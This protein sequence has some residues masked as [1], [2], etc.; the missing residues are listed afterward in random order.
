MMSTEKDGLEFVE[1][2]RRKKA[3]EV[4]ATQEKAKSDLKKENKLKKKLAMEEIE[5]A[6]QF[7]PEE[8]RVPEWF[9]D[10]PPNEFFDPGIFLA[11]PDADVIHLQ[12]KTE[13]K[14]DEESGELITLLSLRKFPRPIICSFVS[15]YGEDVG[16]RKD[17]M[18]GNE[19]ELRAKA[20][21]YKPEDIVNPEALTK[22]VEF[23]IFNNSL[24]TADREL[25]EWEDAQ[26]EPAQIPVAS[27]I[28]PF[29][30]LPDEYKELWERVNVL[31]ISS[32]EDVHYLW[33]T[34][35][36]TALQ[37]IEEKLWH[38]HGPHGL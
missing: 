36:A 15:I 38:I 33:L 20:N 8:L 2:L 24:A 34:A 37:A 9:S 35:K 3:D 27:P 25:K 28:D 4:E 19:F 30:D 1:E 7:F 22:L 13:Y 29:D 11:I 23:A 17:T 10:E 16:I 14:S 18:G 32:A 26:S 5:F 6:M 31:P 12:V 21:I